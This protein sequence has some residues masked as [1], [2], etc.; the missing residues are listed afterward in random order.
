MPRFYMYWVW[1]NQGMCEQAESQLAM[2]ESSQSR[3]TDFER[4]RVRS[5]RADLEGRLLEMLENAGKAAAKSSKFRIATWLQGQYATFVNHPQDAIESLTTIPVDWAPMGGAMA[6][7]SYY[8]AQTYHLK[9]DFEG[10]RRIATERVAHLPDVLNLY[11]QQAMALAAL[12]RLDEVDRLIAACLT[13]PVPRNG[14]PAG[15][16]EDAAYELREHGYRDKALAVAGKEISWLR[17]R[18]DE[19]R[20]RWRFKLARHYILRS[21]GRKQGGSSKSLPVNPR[22]ISIAAALV[23]IQVS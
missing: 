12:G 4:L 19:E 1:R 17:S 6:W 5:F 22:R 8:L 23:E 9:S 10:Q 20:K 2:L 16:M 7:P 21:I 13:I 14:T 3:M 11:G 15:V 18:P